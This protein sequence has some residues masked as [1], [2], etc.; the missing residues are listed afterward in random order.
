MSFFLQEVKSQKVLM[1]P[2]LIGFGHTHTDT[3]TDTHTNTHTQ[4]HTDTHTH[5]HTH[6]KPLCRGAALSVVDPPESWLSRQLAPDSRVSVPM[7]GT[8]GG[9]MTVTRT[10]EDPQRPG[11]G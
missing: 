3:H 1:L 8:R 2:D 7:T 10:V 11:E 6:Y 9:M 4:T 5:T